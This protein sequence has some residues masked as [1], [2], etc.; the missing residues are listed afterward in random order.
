MKLL[1]CEDC[2][3]IRA[4]LPVAHKPVFC[5]CGRHAI[6][7]ED[8]RAGIAR[9]CDTRGRKDGAYAGWPGVARAYII[10][11]TNLFLGADKLTTAADYAEIVEAHDDSYLFKRYGSV[12]IRFRPGESGDT[13]WAGLPEMIE[14]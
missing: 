2:G 8:P 5:R 1:Y 12:A 6:W 9:V 11:L 7:W 14:S 10:G 4:P 3:D 13:R